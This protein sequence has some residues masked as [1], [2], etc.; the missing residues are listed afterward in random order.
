LRFLALG[1]S[2]TIGEKVDAPARW[3]V[4]LVMA[5]RAMRIDVDDPQIVARTGWTTDELAAGVD[6][7]APIGPYAL[8]S[9]MVGVN[10]QYRGRD[11]EQYRTAFASLL[12]RSIGFAGGVP[13][14]VLV[15][16]IPDWGATPF[17]AERD[18][19]RIAKEIDCFNAIGRAAAL[20]VAARWV[21][22]TTASREV[23]EDWVGSDGLHPS[24]TQYARWVEIALH[25]AA[26][27]LAQARSVGVGGGVALR[28]E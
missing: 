16:S 19:T 26:A 28:G 3:P 27:A 5:L 11:A 21:D 24:A 7:V 12:A 1:D 10:D 25:P 4:Q 6:A 22:V 13:G 14:R 23:R 15:L 8:V 2:Y 18:R 9:L 20:G 17:A